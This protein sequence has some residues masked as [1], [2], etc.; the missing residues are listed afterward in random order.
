MKHFLLIDDDEHEFIY[1]KYLFTQHFKEGFHLSYAK[2]L[3]EAINHLAQNTVD[4]ILLDDKLGRGTNS[5]DTVPALQKKAPK[6]PLIIISK[7]INGKH[8]NVQNRLYEHKIVDKFELKAELA[9]G[10]FD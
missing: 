8:L 2:N 6:V 7:D 9:N 1:V 5:T 3:T 4:M 10:V